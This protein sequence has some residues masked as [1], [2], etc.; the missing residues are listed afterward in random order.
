MEQSRANNNFKGSKMDVCEMTKDNM[1][2]LMEKINRKHKD[3]TES[4][5]SALNTL[6][7]AFPVG[8]KVFATVALGELH[9]D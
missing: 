1:I 7:S 2:A 9:I 3:N 6:V 5:R 8:G 4:R